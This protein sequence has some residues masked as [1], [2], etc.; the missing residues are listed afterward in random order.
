MSIFHSHNT[1]L[2]P[3]KPKYYFRHLK[4]SI[5]EFY[6]KY[7]LLPADKAANTVVVVCRLHYINILKQ[8]LSGTKAYKGTSTDEVCSF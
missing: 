3:P 5:Q 7:V 4:Q 8:E 1:Y 2:L 6:R